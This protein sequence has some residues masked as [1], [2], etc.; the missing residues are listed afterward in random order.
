MQDSKLQERTEESKQASKKERRKTDCIYI[1][2]L[3]KVVLSIVPLE[4][5]F[6]PHSVLSIHCRFAW[7]ADGLPGSC[8]IEV[9]EVLH[10]HGALSK[11]VSEAAQE[12]LV[13]STI[14]ERYLLHIHKLST[15]QKH[16]SKLEGRRK[17]SD[18]NIGSC[19]KHLQ[20]PSVKSE[21]PCCLQA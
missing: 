8:L 9:E 4:F 10:I 17:H 13:D 14:L 11:Q 2:I 3:L 18:G 19:S 5:V 20:S 21:R 1:Y 12:T 16:Q 15:C 7:V 6:P